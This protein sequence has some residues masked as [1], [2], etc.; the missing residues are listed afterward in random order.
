MVIDEEQRFGVEHKEKV[1]GL[2]GSGRFD[3]DRNP[4][5]EDAAHVFDRDSRYQCH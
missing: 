2:R 5:T 4:H 1:K 3:V